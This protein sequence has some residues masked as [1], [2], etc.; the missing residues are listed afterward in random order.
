[1]QGD[2]VILKCLIFN[3]CREVASVKKIELQD[4][5]FIAKVGEVLY[6]MITYEVDEKKLRF[7]KELYEK[8]FNSLKVN[9]ISGRELNIYFQKNIRQKFMIMKSLRKLCI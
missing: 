4:G 7:W 3:C 2:G 1:M 6:T 9:R 5:F 8:N